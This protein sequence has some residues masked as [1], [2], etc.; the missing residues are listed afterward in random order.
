MCVKGPEFVF[1]FIRANILLITGN[2]IQRIEGLEA[3]HDLRELVLDRN[4]IKTVCEMSFINQWN[5]QELHLEENRLKELTNLNCLEN[6]QRLYLGSNRVQVG[7]LSTL[8]TLK[9]AAI[10]TIFGRKGENHK[11]KHFLHIV[12]N[13]V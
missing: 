9:K 10:Y 1:N 6:L 13:P 7:A 8:C 4:K 5:L 3:L 11:S 12:F 2:E